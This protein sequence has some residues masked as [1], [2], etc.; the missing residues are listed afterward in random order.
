YA[1]LPSRGKTKS[2][3][4]VIGAPDGRMIRLV[5]LHF[6]NSDGRTVESPVFE[7]SIY[8]LAA[9]TYRNG[10]GVLKLEAYPAN[11]PPRRKKGIVVFELRDLPRLES[12]FD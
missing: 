10:Q 1:R 9:L 5:Y 11:K 12:D 7:I 4:C 2:L 8:R 3:S 6:Q